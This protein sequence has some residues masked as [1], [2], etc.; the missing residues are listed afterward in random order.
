MRGGYF[1]ASGALHWLVV[2]FPCNRGKPSSDLD[3]P[4]LDGKARLGLGA[5]QICWSWG[6]LQ[7]VFQRGLRVPDDV[8]LVG[9]D[10]IEFAAAA[11]VPL[12]SV[13]QPRRLLGRTA[14]ELLLEELA[15]GEH[16]HL[17]MLFRPELVV[18]ASSSPDP[19]GPPRGGLTLTSQI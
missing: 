17:Q 19:P 10:D 3:R 2:G 16:R 6:A 11:A 9:Y 12:S 5:D 18:R 7:D 14:A 4:K 8:A 1:F 13:R 15:G